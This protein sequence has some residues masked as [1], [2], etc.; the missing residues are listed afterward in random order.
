MEG[1]HAVGDIITKISANCVIKL[2]VALLFMCSFYGFILCMVMTVMY[3]YGYFLYMLH[4]Y[5][6]CYFSV[7]LCIYRCICMPTFYI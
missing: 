3:I 1:L 5:V 4:V 7:N 2:H 6:Y